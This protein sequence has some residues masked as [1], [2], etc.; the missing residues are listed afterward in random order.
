[1]L[2]WLL[3]YFKPMSQRYSNFESV[4]RSSGGFEVW[5]HVCADAEPGWEYT[6]EGKASARA[7]KEEERQKAKAE[8]EAAKERAQAT[9]RQRKLCLETKKR[10]KEEAD[11]AKQ[12]EKRQK[13]IVEQEAAAREAAELLAAQEEAAEE[14]RRKL[15]VESAERERVKEEKERRRAREAAEAVVRRELA[16]EEQRRKIRDAEEATALRQLE[17]DADTE[18]VQTG[19]E[20][21]ARLRTIVRAEYH[22]LAREHTRLQDVHD[23]AS[24][25]RWLERRRRARLHVNNSHSAE[26]EPQENH[27]GHDAER[28]RLAEIAIELADLEA[29]L[30]A[31]AKFGIQAPTPSST[32]SCPSSRPTAPSSLTNSTTDTDQPNH[33]QSSTALSDIRVLTARD[34]RLD[35]QA[36]QLMR[37]R[38]DFLVQREEQRRV[39]AM[40]H[41]SS[42]PPGWFGICTMI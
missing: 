14:E 38:Y 25:R 2:F 3:S 26:N 1:M 23:A 31:I 9:E 37:D 18:L 19:E 27:E 39:A 32:D 20:Q 15:A 40:I 13:R 17:K 30:K 21:W 11:K 33:H 5:Y 7:R 34:D 28:A 4:N 42:P 24:A 35:N 36:D 41:V 10:E 16:E 8:K 22:D 12:E 29:V 6:P